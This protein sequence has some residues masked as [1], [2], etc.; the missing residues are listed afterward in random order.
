VIRLVRAEVRKVRSTRLWIGLGLGGLGLT[1]LATLL[2]LSPANTDQGRLSG[3]HPVA[4]AEDL[5]RL[6]FD[7]AGVLAFVL[8]LATTMAT[9]E[10][11]YGTAVGTYLATPSRLRVVTAKALAAAPIGFVYGAAA[12]LVVVLLAVGWLAAKG[13]PVPFGHPRSSASPRSACRAPTGPSSRSVSARW[14]AANWSR[15]SA[16]WGGCSWTEPLATAVQ[17][18]LTRWTRSPASTAPSA[19][20]RSGCR[21]V[22]AG[23]RAALAA[24]YVALLWGP[25]SGPRGVV[26]PRACALALRA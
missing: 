21:A 11:R 3:L 17:P 19:D 26:T 24:A 6:V 9:S 25:P 16:C 13:E 5:R 1:G 12:G 23:G 8:V 10:F 20:D 2:L 14:C 4:T 15:S 18:A 22:R 7:A